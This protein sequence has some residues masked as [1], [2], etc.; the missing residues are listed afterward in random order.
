LKLNE[1]I[2]GIDDLRLQSGD[3]AIDVRDVTLD[4][5]RVKAGALFAALP[6]SK[7]DGRSF[8]AAAA[9]AGASVILAPEGSTFLDLPAGVAV[10]T[11]KEPRRALARLAARF[12]GHQ[13]PCIAAVTGTGGKTSTV[14]FARQLWTLEGREAASLGTLGIL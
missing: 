8:V 6:G 12:F 11:A 5:R 2:L 9:K 7:A 3:A 13:P 4:S 10:L 1:L 14:A